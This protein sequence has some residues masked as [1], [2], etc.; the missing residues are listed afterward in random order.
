MNRTLSAIA[1]TLGLTG[2]T[3]HASAQDEALQ[4]EG[5]V[6]LSEAPAA[7][8]GAQGKLR[9]YGGLRLGFGGEVEFKP[10]GGGATSKDDLLLTL[11]G[12]GGVDYVIMD[13]F[14]LGGELRLAGVNTES[15]DDADIGGDVII[16]VAVK[17]RGRYALSGIPLEIYGTLP[18]GVSFIKTSGDLNKGGVE[19]SQGPGL[20]LGIGAGATYF[21][22]DNL[23][24]NGE[25]AYLMYWYGATSE[26]TFAGVKTKAEADISFGQLSL[27]ANLV[28]AL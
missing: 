4:E 28:Y 15:R 27:F 10:D 6:E 16:D 3:A 5:S 11:G 22:T 26:A 8:T 14:A 12:Q 1:I 20:N 2:L 17:P 19:F 21:F 23:G 24:I 13:F 7:A 9:V 25:M 18:I